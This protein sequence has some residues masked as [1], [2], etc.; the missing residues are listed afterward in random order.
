[1]RAD[2]DQ[3]RFGADG[4]H[5]AGHHQ[6]AQVRLAPPPGPFDGQSRQQ[7]VQHVEGREVDDDAVPR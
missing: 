7:V 5:A 4:R 2:I 6:V 1:V 3:W